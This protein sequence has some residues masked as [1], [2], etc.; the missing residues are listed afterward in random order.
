VQELVL[1]CATWASMTENGIDSIPMGDFWR[2]GADAHRH[3]IVQSADAIGETMDDSFKKSG[4]LH[5]F[6]RVV[7]LRISG[8]ENGAT[9]T[10]N[11]THQFRYILRLYSRNP[12][13]RF[14][15]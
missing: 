11:R 9:G 3:G 2:K 15:S 5:V 13:W 8:N 7:A 14:E 12:I 6:V 4:R 1:P 10:Y